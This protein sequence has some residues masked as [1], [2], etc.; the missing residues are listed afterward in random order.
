MF[1]QLA[2]FS[3][4][5]FL[6]ACGNETP[7]NQKD[8]VDP[9]DSVKPT[10]VSQPEND[11]ADF[12]FHVLVLNIP[13]PFEII[14][15]LPKAGLSYNASM[16]N[17]TDNE[18]KYATSTKKGLNYGAYVVDLVYLST[19]EQYAQ[20]KSY[21]KT[22][23]SLASSLGAAQSFDKITGSRLEKNIDSKDTINKIVDQLY[24]EMDN[25]LR[26]NDRLLTATQILI[27]SWVESQYI[28]LSLVK[29][30]AKT[31]DNA[32]LFDKIYEQRASV[33]KLTEL[34]KEYEKEKDLKSTIQDVNDLAKIYQELKQGDPDKA[35]LN[36][37][38]DKLK[39][40]REKMVK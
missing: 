2:L 38:F 19:N 7:D 30:A 15:L 6:A 8:K 11:M 12:K 5:I 20:V 31:K 40:V 21:F 32:V 14:S 18:S 36:K 34:L 25:Y 33:A 16:V 22:S 13:S 35:L 1:K 4:V 37:L 23:R 17:S 26:S 29:D 28:T 39:M 24:S 9:K 27:G 10:S 3:F